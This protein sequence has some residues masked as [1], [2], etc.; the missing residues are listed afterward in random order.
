MV[1]VLLVMSSLAIIT[2]M[3]VLTMIRPGEGGAFSIGGPSP[4][5]QKVYKRFVVVVASALIVAKPKVDRLLKWI[6]YSVVA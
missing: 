2:V 6:G 4:C 5:F 1:R 3:M